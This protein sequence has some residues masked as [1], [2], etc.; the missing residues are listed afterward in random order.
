MINAL[1]IPPALRPIR[2]GFSPENVSRSGGVSIT[3]G[4]Q[5][6][7]SASGRWRARAV[8]NV[9]REDRVLAWRA[10]I[11]SLNGRAGLLEIG[12]FDF[13]RPADANGRRVSNVE[14]AQVSGLGFLFD[15]S[16]FGQQDFTF[17]TLAAGA[18][19]RATRITIN[20]ANSWQAP[21]AGQYFGIGQRLY[22][23]TAIYRAA[24]SGPWTVDFWPQLRAAASAGERIITDRPICL[25]R[26]AS[27]EIGGL[28]LDFGRI[29]QASLDLVEVL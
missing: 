17:A 28:D 13:H 1:P 4:E 2:V 22:I 27:D 19:L 29:G 18:A 9:L 14:A 12:P 24:N 5:V 16:G 10:F 21:R 20:A 6:V 23:V 7:A 3:G 25:M 15:H 8:F 26:L 11:A